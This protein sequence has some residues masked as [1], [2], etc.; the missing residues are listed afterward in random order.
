[1]LV[2]LMVRLFFLLFCGFCRT[3]VVWL[4]VILKASLI[5]Q[6]IA[7]CCSELLPSTVI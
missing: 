7:L 2:A 5:L 4:V 3:E 6:Y 1:M